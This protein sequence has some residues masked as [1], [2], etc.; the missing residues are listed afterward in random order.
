MGDRVFL[1]TNIIVYLYSIDEDEKRNVACQFVNNSDCITSIQVMNEANNVWFKK[2]KLNKNQIIKYLDEIEFVCE[3]V[4]LVRRKTI[5][6]AMDIKDIYGY[7]L[8]LLE[9]Q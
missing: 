4:M 5:N 7:I 8:F 1:D 3:E 2:H 9:R 6:L